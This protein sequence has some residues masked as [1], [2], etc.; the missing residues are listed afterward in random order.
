MKPQRL[1]AEKVQIAEVHNDIARA[2]DSH[3]FSL[4]S[5]S[6]DTEMN[7]LDAQLPVV[8]VQTQ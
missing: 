7:G 1:R 5:N 6:V 4:G 3:L 2:A 8:T